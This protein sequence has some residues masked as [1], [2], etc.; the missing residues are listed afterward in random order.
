MT[1]LIIKIKNMNI[2]KNIKIYHFT[3]K[4]KEFL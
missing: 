2:C 1:V 3:N 4:N